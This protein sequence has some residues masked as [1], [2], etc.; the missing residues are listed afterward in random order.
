MQSPIE[1]HL[2]LAHDVARFEQ[3][4]DCCAELWRIDEMRCYPVTPKMNVASFNDVEA[5]APLERTIA[6]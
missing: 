6:F 3:R 4:G 1:H 2:L 5:T